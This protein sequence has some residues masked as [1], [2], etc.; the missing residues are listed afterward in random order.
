MT[1][2]KKTARKST[3]KAAS[4]KSRATSKPTGPADVAPKP[5][6]KRKARYAALAKS[7]KDARKDT[8]QN[9]DA[10]YE[11]IAEVLDHE[12]FLDA[13]Y[14]SATQWIEEVV[15]EPARTVQRNARVAKYATPAEEERYGVA[16]LDS[17]L[18]YIEAV[19]GG[20]TKVPLPVRFDTLKITITDADGT[21]KK[22]SL[23]EAS[24]KDID[25]A[26]KQLVASDEP[27]AAERRSPA[28]RAIVKALRKFASLAA[29]TVSVSDAK[30]K[31]GELPLYA[32][33]DLRKA[34]AN[35]RLDER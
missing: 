2:P 13:G 26:R 28:E 32:L 20:P 9:F 34:L 27:A 33:D 11:A 31:L 16:K 21:R 17:A 12:L 4:S 6:P 3:P 1:P 22:L 24:V 30:L 35:V 14:R 8:L 15:K 7:I 5:D 19:A 10:L 29:V 23:E 25:A 18:D